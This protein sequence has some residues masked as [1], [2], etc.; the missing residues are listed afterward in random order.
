MIKAFFLIFEPVGAWNRIGMA[1]RKISTILAFYL[2]PM[3]LIVAVVEGYGL[4]AFGRARPPFGQ[5]RTYSVQEAFQ[6]EGAQMVLMAIVIMLSAYIVKAFG[7]TFRS[8]NTYTQ[9]FTVVAYAL[10]PLFLL[11]LLD[12]IPT[13]SLWVFWGMGIVLVAKTLY[14]GVPRIMEPDPP[15]A[16]GLF[17]MTALLIA[18][19]TAGERAI[20]WGYLAGKYAPVSEV[21]KHLLKRFHLGQ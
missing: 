15:H 5:I 6:Y 2:L 20:S 18:L 21:I 7:E 4:V 9:T 14:I 19:A 12:V 10:S 17:F 1:N 16:Y 8:R 13:I 3:M 11:R